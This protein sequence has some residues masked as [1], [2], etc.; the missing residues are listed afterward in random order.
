MRWS[1][2][3]VILF[4]PA[5]SSVAAQDP[6]SYASAVTGIPVQILLAISL[7]ESSHHPLYVKL[8]NVNS[9]ARRKR[10][11]TAPCHTMTSPRLAP[12]P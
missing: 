5:L 1:L 2:A 6:F 8:S 10:E 3:F 9:V 4:F 7:L 11:P 12:L